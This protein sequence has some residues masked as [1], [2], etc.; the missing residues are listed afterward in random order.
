[1]GY[2]FHLL[3]DHRLAWYQM[4]DIL[5][6]PY[7]PIW[8]I[9][10]RHRKHVWKQH[11]NY[12]GYKGNHGRSHSEIHQNLL[13]AIKHYD[14]I[15]PPS[16]QAPKNLGKKTIWWIFWYDI[17]GAVCV[18]VLTE[19]VPL[20]A[21]SACRLPVS[22][23]VRDDGLPRPLYRTQLPHWDMVSWKSHHPCMLL[24]WCG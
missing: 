21:M 3:P 5:S 6:S 4:E 10:I 20:V 2:W 15:S 23:P 8:C 18:A 13:R 16:F 19:D 7:W 14:K 12:E 1:M 22:L 17:F 11:V 24:I 9:L